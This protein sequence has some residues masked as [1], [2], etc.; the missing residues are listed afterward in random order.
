MRQN[1][2]GSIIQVWYNFLLFHNGA[3]C[4]G[5][6]NGR[7]QKEEVLQTDI[8]EVYMMVILHM[9]IEAHLCTMYSR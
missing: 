8:Q 9:E 2:K 3:S 6:G 5:S 4:G 7:I 1:R